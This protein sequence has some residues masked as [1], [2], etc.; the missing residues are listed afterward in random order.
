MYKKAKHKRIYVEDP[1]FHRLHDN[2]KIRISGDKREPEPKH[3]IM[4]RVRYG[5]IVNEKPVCYTIWFCKLG[6]AYKFWL[7]MVNDVDMI[8]IDPIRFHGKTDTMPDYF[9]YSLE[10]LTMGVI[11]YKHCA[12]RKDNKHIYRKMMW[13]DGCSEILRKD[14]M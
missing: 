7:S 1:N 2:E 4:Y 3:D 9:Y 11:W 14:E 10:E 13:E 5:W 12:S 8:H 6:E